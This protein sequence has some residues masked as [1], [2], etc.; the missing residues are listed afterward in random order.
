MPLRLLCK[1]YGL[2]LLLILIF[3]LLLTR[4]LYFI[5]GPLISGN[6]PF[7]FE[8][9]PGQSTYDIAAA[10]EAKGYLPGHQRRYF[11]WLARFSGQSRHLRVG[12]YVFQPGDSAYR[13]LHKVSHG[14]VVIQNITLVDGWTADKVLQVV[15]SDS[16]LQ[17]SPVLLSREALCNVL[18]LPATASLEGM[19]WPNTYALYPGYS[20]LLLLQRAHRLMEDNLNLLWATRAPNL[21][22]RTPYEALIIASL[23][24]QETASAEERRL[25]AGVLINRLK[26]GMY[27]QIDP[28][29][30][31]ALGSRYKGHLTR[32]DLKIDSPYNTYK[33][34]GLPP[35]PIALPSLDALMAALHP[36][37]SD[38]LYFVARGDGL[39]TF[40]ATLAEHNVAVAQYLK[41][42]ASKQ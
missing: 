38:Y 30:I 17:H 14:E 37:M 28:T 20:D 7:Y 31:Y 27:L 32:A 23:I 19:F 36:T 9:S 34:K 1:R 35:T 24:E 41:Q 10:L 15:M 4:A 16:R 33:Y 18:G 40:S 6:T 26:L 39:H 11:Y 3:I 13:I 22:Y 2:V 21:P 42:G 5:Y 8:L 25:I 12:Y 29:V